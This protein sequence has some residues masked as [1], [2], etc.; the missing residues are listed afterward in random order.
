MRLK[1]KI[2][3][4]YSGTTIALLAICFLVVYW[5]FA[6][7]REEDFQQRQK[8]KI[9][10][11]FRFITEINKYESELTEA[12]DRLTINSLLNEKLLIF[13]ST[14]TLIYAS[15]DDVPIT[16][17][18][19]LLSRLNT[20]DVWI[21]QKDGLYDVV[22]IYFKS[23]NQH[24]YGIS[25]AYDQFGYTKLHF[26]RNLLLI[27][28]IV[29]SATVVLLCIYIANRIAKPISKLAG[30]L[31][32]YQIGDRP[33]HLND[34]THTFEIDYLN[35]RF[36][37]LVA[38]VNNAY[39]FQKHATQHIS[40]QL[41]TPIAVL[42]SELERMQR[43]AT[44][45]GMKMDLQRQI[46]NTKSL[47]DIVEVLLQISKIESGQ[48]TSKTEVRADELIYDVLNE[49]AMLHPNFIFEVN[50]VPDQP[51][52]DHLSIY[53]NEMLF[54]QAMQNLM[55]NAITY[56]ANGRADITIDCT[57]AS[58]LRIAIA[59]A[60]PAITRQEKAFLFSHF[61]RGE[62][63]RSKPGFGLGL[64]L[65]KKI[66]ELHDGSLTYSGNEENNNVFEIKL[67]LVLS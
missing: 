27:T 36:A 67:P 24:Y 47:A 59:N 22:A 35:S 34:A 16:Y 49:L 63:S 2:L 19:Q 5:L 28:F 42:I 21:E 13:D 55:N 17:S 6:E 48:S 44:K 32:A 61:F 4:Y 66:I 60:G 51:D 15:L 52:N 37:D 50:Y 33:L 65:A 20:S 26:L 62:N 43:S 3:I 54:K 40:H 25:K 8:E 14:K 29:F 57:T 23:N 64:T 1:N 41:K 18:K 58:Q 9:L 12:V 31:A 38:R 39:T 56:S 7:Y 53:V 11:T 30:L 46:S 10:T 45:P